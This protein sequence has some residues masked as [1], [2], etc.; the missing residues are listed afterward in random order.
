MNMKCSVYVA[1]SLD[2]YIALSDWDIS[3]LDNMPNPEND[4]FGFSEFMST[5]D[6]IIMWR[7]TF[8]KVLT[9]WFWP[10][11]KPVFILSSKIIDIPNELKW[12]VEQI[13]WNPKEILLKASA[14]GFGSLYI[15][16]WKTIQS[17]IEENLINEITITRV[18]ILLWD[19][20]PLFSKNPKIQELEHIETSVLLN[21]LV[22][23]RYKFKTI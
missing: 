1:T 5:I 14:F 10:Y 19:W 7:K 23:S 11:D 16:W 21:G 3:W 13:A 8:E 17:F 20:I 4:D 6:A 18:P 2:W 15:D 22:K 12:K 9:F